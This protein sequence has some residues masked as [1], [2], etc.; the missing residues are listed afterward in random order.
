MTSAA[1]EPAPGYLDAT[2]VLVEL[3]IGRPLRH[4]EQVV[5]VFA[6]TRALDNAKDELHRAIEAEKARAVRRGLR[7]GHPIRLRMTRPMLAALE[8]L[9]RLGRREA[10]RELRA[11]GITAARRAFAD[12]EPAEPALPQLGDIAARLLSHLNGLSVRLQ[13]R[14][15][16]LEASAGGEIAD[17]LARALLRQPGGRSIAA[18]LVSPALFGGLGE[19]FEQNQDLV[20]GWE[21]SAVLDGG[22]CDR[23]APLD[24]TTYPSWDAIQG[25]LPNGGPNPDCLGGGRCRCRAVPRGP[26]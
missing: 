21:Y 18:A 15:V 19:T 8:R 22:T 16:E 13:N 3:T 11:H 14:R 24:G 7:T 25:V 2:R 10:L 4:A 12:P 5:D 26:A 20:G 17:A 1:T 9:W 6:L 23:C